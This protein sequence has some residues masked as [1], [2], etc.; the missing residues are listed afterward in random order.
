M[1]TPLSLL[2]TPLSREKKLKSSSQV[3]VYDE[4]IDLL[5]LPEFDLIVTDE[6]KHR[7]EMYKA[8]ENRKNIQE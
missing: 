8:E 6:A 4:N 2:M 1:S 5:S 7:R 3:R